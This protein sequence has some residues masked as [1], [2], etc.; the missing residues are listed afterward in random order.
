MVVKLKATDVFQFFK[1]WI[2]SHSRIDDVEVFFSQLP[3]D[4][5]VTW[6]NIFPKNNPD[7]VP[8]LLVVSGKV[9]VHKT[10][11]SSFLEE[12]FFSL[13]LKSSKTA[14]GGAYMWCYFTF[15]GLMFFFVLFCVFYFLWAG[16]HK[17][18]TDSDASQ[19]FGMHRSLG[20]R[21]PV[22]FSQF[23]FG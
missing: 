14:S 13:P 8:G 3:K 18:D 21:I 17:G 20:L 12:F 16:M 15:S 1:N 7:V 4:S 9:F 22:S 6:K 19:A 5:C 11:E 10:A 23:A 2:Y